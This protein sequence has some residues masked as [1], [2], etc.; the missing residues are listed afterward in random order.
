[1]AAASALTL[2]LAACGGTGSSSN[3]GS[4]AKYQQGG[5]A[6]STKNAA[7]KGPAAPVPNAVSG[8]NVTV[9]L[10]SPD[11]GPST[12]DPTGGWSVTGNSIQQDL[13]NRSLTTFMRDPKTGK[14][15][16]VPDLATDLGTHNADFTQWKFTLKPGL[17]YDNGKPISAGDVAWA[18]A[19]SFDANTIAGAGTQYSTQYFLDGDKYKGPYDKSSKGKKY[20]GTSVSGSTITIKMKQPFP[21]MDYWGSFMAMGPIPQ[22]TV[23]NPPKYGNKPWATGPYKVQS[24][25]PNKELV[26]VKNTQ[27]DP[28]SDPARHQYVDSWDFKFDQDP[29]ATDQVSLSNNTASQTTITTNVQAQN[30]SDA[31][32]KLGQRLVQG[33]SPCTSF[34]YPDYTKITNIKV[35]QALGFA[36]PYENSWSAAGEVVG[37]TRVPGNSILPPGLSGRQEYGP[38]NGGQVTY[39]PKKAKQL[40]SEAGVKPNTYKITFVY[41]K[42]DP[43]AVKSKDQIVAGL[44]ASGFVPNPLGVSGSPYD[45]WLNPTDKVNKSLNLRGVAWCSDWPSGLTFIPPLFQTGQLYNTGHFSEAAID[46]KIKS[47]PSMPAAQQPAAWAALDKEVETKY[48]PAINLGYINNLF[49]YGSKI[50]N[51][52]NDS[53]IGAPDYRDIYVMK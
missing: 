7:A 52:N 2:T 10:P 26:L 48:Y 35:R 47:I 24:F 45:T 39:D 25:S 11:T 19:R 21:D 20:A 17:K 41:K 33:S 30:Y 46:S 36:Y 28:N 31:K 14:M 4:T 53:A 43:N 27:W 42:D 38:I 18:V 15:V 13:V 8:G 5:S 16:L 9:L 3:G 49:T 12:L 40:L 23:S 51:F 32:S 34:W 1:V 29:E 22:G 6:G 44:K 50:G 37:V